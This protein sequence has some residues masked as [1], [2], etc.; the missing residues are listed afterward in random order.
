MTK[1]NAV[2]SVTNQTEEEK[3]Q[4]IDMESLSIAFKH[5]FS[6]P[7]GATAIKYLMN[8]YHFLGGTF[9]PEPNMMYFNEGERSVLVHILELVDIPLEAVRDIQEEVKNDYSS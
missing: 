5:A 7:H 4:K 2:K 6:G 1:A 9:N 3:K 8:R